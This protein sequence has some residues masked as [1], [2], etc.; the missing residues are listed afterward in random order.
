MKLLEITDIKKSYTIDKKLETQILHGVSLSFNKGEFVSILGESGCGKS[1]LMNIIGGMDSNYT[2]DVLA[3]GK[4]LK[5]MKESELD[6]YRKSKIG[7]VFQSFNLIP[8]LTVL[9]NVMIAMQMANKSEKERKERAIQL[10]AEVGL[11]DHMMK[12][13]NQLSGG[14]KQR[15]S[16]ARA[17]S[18]DPDI[19]L[20]DEPTG[21]LDKETSQQ[22]LDLLNDIAKKGK[23]V[24]TVT[25]S[26]KV[27]DS[28]TRIVKIE[29]GRV[30]EDVR[31]K[32]AYR[33]VE[34]TEQT[35]PKSLSLMSSI[36]L[37]LK[38]MK[39]NAKRNIL[40]AIGGSIGIISV[41][42]MLSLGSGV[43][44]FINDEINSSMNPL[45][46]EITKQA[47]DNGNG[48][49]QSMPMMLAQEPFTE[50][51]IDQ[52]KNIPNVSSIEKTTAYNMKSNAVFGD[53]RSDIIQFSTLTNSI[54]EDNVETGKLP[55]DNEILITSTL[56]KALSSS[57]QYESIVGQEISVYVNDVGPDNKPVLVE[58]TW[59]V[60]GVYNAGN[61]GPQ[62]MT[63]AY[64]PYETLETAFAEQGLTLHPTQINAFADKKEH[65]EGI[66][67]TL[68]EEGYANSQT[69]AMLEQVTT[70]LDMA[71]VILAGISG[72]SL[73][74][75]GIMILVVLYISVVERTKEIGIL[76]AI[77]A[78][79][80]DVK[81]IF[82]SESALL[83]LFSGLIA[84]AAGMG[85][86]VIGNSLLAKSF[87]AELINLTGSTMLF[88]IAVSLIVSIIAGLMPSSKAAKLDPM[89]SLRFE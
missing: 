51:N 23:L 60:S 20:A 77:G 87:G 31:L 55:A 65:V 1:T 57:E 13:P 26:Q 67:E 40:V 54:K 6:D 78:R 80:K 83:G 2:G 89:E 30:V 22:I 62:G 84:A 19:I 24:I 29:D 4:N 75:S 34:K 63:A 8:H 69:A 35:N 49:E 16:I 59:K 76:R 18:N 47:E 61:M 66:K 70:Y 72:I 36:K 17:L 79:K 38:N 37:A 41:I 12:K 71:T 7:F 73:I 44:N 39:L 52:I 32:D 81:R 42:L 9:E 3:E 68:K 11:Q 14:Q 53:K 88:G 5:N 33:S 10:L 56:A 64:V 82:F 15:V 85:I 86:S 45:M 58:A 46:I 21:A 43:T 50:E 74:V 48:P 27:A 25:H 28:G